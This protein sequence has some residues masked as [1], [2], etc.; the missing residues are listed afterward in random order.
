MD[1]YLKNFYIQKEK[2]LSELIVEYR[3]GILT[4]LSVVSSL[5]PLAGPLLA[6][7]F[8]LADAYIYYKEEEYL[9]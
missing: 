2:N 9:C 1:F 7:T 3:H 5:I 8:D 6:L 4:T